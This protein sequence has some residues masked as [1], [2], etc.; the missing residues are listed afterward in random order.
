MDQVIRLPGSCRSANPAINGWKN[1]TFAEWSCG[2]KLTFPK[3]GRV[4][5]VHEVTVSAFPALGE[6]YKILR[7]TEGRS[8]ELL[9]IPMT[10]NVTFLQSVLGQAKGGATAEYP[11]TRENEVTSWSLARHYSSWLY[12]RTF[13]KNETN[14]GITGNWSA[15]EAQVLMITLF[16]TLKYNKEIWEIN[17]HVVL[18]DIDARTI[19]RRKFEW[20]IFRRKFDDEDFIQSNHWW[21]RSHRE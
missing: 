21:C 7:A 5:E 18:R 9:L 8:R 19:F 17:D 12:L 16:F 15:F 11:A 13:L 2:K 4:A 1:L 6:G 3:D 20:F 10:P 14:A